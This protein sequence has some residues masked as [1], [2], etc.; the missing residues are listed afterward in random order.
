MSFSINSTLVLNLNKFLN[1]RINE[2]NIETFKIT[3]SLQAFI[4][5]KL[6]K[7]KF[8]LNLK[9]IQEIF[10]SERYIKNMVGISRMKPFS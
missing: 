2:L 7:Q 1:I 9:S 6:T 5:I 4:A 3:R 8:I 10:L